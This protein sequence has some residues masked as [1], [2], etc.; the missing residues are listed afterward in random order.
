MQYPSYT[1]LHFDFGEIQLVRNVTG[2]NVIDVP[3]DLAE[4]EGI[5]RLRRACSEFKLE[6][7]EDRNELRAERKQETER[8]RRKLG[9]LG[10][11]KRRDGNAGTKRR[12]KTE[13][14]P[15]MQAQQRGS[16]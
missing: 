10:A 3:H 15:V 7:P 9:P 2:P 11:W 6:G 8:P 5:G 12:D 13:R 4:I 14:F 1:F 16:A